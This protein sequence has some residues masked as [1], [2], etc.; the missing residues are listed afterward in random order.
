MRAPPFQ[1]TWNVTL[2]GSAQD[3]RGEKISARGCGLLGGCVPS[4]QLIR[5]MTRGH[6]SRKS[7]KSARGV[8]ISL[9]QAKKSPDSVEAFWFR[10]RA[11]LRSLP[12]RDVVLAGQ[13]SEGLDTRHHG[14]KITMLAPDNPKRAIRLPPDRI[15]RQSSNPRLVLLAFGEGERKTG[16]LACVV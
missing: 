11:T 13:C 8:P 6:T 1:D 7:A 15:L 9:A 10:L 5:K 16:D 2:G 12:I 3:L 14:S 4:V